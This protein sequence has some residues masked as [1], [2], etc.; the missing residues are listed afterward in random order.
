MVQIEFILVDCQWGE[1]NAWDSS[2]CLAPCAGKT[3]TRSRIKKQELQDGGQDCSGSDT[4]ERQ[5][6]IQDCK[7][8]QCV[9]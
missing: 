2:Q 6:N 1:W 3:E 8:R 4:E 5:C 7:G 9:L